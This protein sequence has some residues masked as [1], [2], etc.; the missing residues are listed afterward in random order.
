[1][2]TRD[3]AL[4]APGV[5]CHSRRI[6]AGLIWVSFRRDPRHLFFTPSILKTVGPAAGV[7]RNG[8]AFPSAES[9]SHCVPRNTRTLPS[10]LRHLG[11]A[12]SIPSLRHDVIDVITRFNGEALTSIIGPKWAFFAATGGASTRRH[13]LL[14]NVHA[15]GTRFFYLLQGEAAS[16]WNLDTCCVSQSGKSL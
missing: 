10:D 9:G 2:F 8:N 12:A 5:K 11:L 13:P 7:Q 15:L 3:T 14:V 6:F 1:M 16:G 4:V